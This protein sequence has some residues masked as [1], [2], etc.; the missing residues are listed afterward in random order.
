MCRRY[1]V[2]NIISVYFI[3]AIHKI[4]MEEIVWM[5]ATFFEHMPKMQRMPINVI[6][7]SSFNRF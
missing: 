1:D 7:R 5:A 2:N 4:R 6:I 3:Y